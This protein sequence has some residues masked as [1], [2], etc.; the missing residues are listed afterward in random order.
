M[1]SAKAYVLRQRGVVPAFEDIRVSDNLTR[2]QVLVR[3]L[4][5]GLCATQIEEIFVASRNQKHM[6]HLFGH[7]GVGVIEAVGPDVR[8][9]KVGEVCVIHWR[10]S[11]IGLDAD[12]GIYFS[13][14]EKLGS[15]KV[16]TFST[17]VVV[18]ENRLSQVPEKFPLEKAAL[19]GCSLTTGW[20]SIVKVGGFEKT[21]SV[22]ITGLGAV[23]TF[24]AWTSKL[25]GSTRVVG[26]DP[27]LGDASFTRDR[28]ADEY[29]ENLEDL[30]RV[31]GFEPTGDFPK[32]VIETSGDSDLVGRL[33]DL[34]PVTSKIVLVGMP[35]ESR[36][37]QLNSQRLLDG[38]QLFGS[39]G[40][41]VDPAVD[42]ERVSET[43]SSV[44]DHG[45]N[46]GLRVLP[47]AD[48]LSKALTLFR[49]GNHLRITLKMN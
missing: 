4:Y 13:G 25:L 43:F 40:G 24:A 15:G 34:V 19:L 48:G 33:F 38:V 39:N 21:D 37:V 36:R 2:G 23:G 6:P 26:I 11:S 31:A 12:P 49:E 45:F 41:A 22:L 27:K 1:I 47:K 46:W 35:K 44:I 20:G 14:D 16:T 10:E 42:L 3:V 9:R 28:G 7:E 18:P 8:H 30:E 5:S 29:F 17:F 32:L